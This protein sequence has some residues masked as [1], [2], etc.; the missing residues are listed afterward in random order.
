MFYVFYVSN[1]SLRYDQVF[2]FCIISFFYPKQANKC[3]IVG[4]RMRNSLETQKLSTEKS[5]DSYFTCGT[6]IK[7]CVM[8]SFPRGSLTAILLGD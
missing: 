3:F 8:Y 2:I 6:I 5:Y 7:V 4:H 1:T